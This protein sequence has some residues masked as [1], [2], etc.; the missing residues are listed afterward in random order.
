MEIKTYAQGGK[1]SVEF[2]LQAS[3]AD[4]YNKYKWYKYSDTEG[5]EDYSS[6]AFLNFTGDSVMVTLSDG[7]DVDDDGVADSRIVVILGLEAS[8]SSSMPFWRPLISSFRSGQNRES[9]M[10][11]HSSNLPQC[12]HQEKKGGPL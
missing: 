2:Y 5:W 3:E 10:V 6:K 1:V 12:N 8:K 11:K 4:K 7:G 9:V